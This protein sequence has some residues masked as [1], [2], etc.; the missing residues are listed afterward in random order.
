MKN[1]FTNLSKINHSL[2]NIVNDSAKTCRYTFCK[3]FIT[4]FVVVKSVRHIFL[5]LRFGERRYAA[6]VEHIYNR[7]AVSAA[8]FFHG[9][10]VI[11]CGKVLR[12]FLPRIWIFFCC[13]NEFRLHRRHKHDISCRI[14]RDKSGKHEFNRAVK[15]VLA[16]VVKRA[17]RYAVVKIIDAAHDNDHVAVRAN[18]AH[19]LHKAV[20]SIACNGETGAFFSQVL[21][22]Y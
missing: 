10:Y 18:L 22:K 4:F 1:N 12:I 11:V 5:L 14:L 13:V 6:F 16:T 8:N 7:N 19:T 2:L 21:T 9:V 15:C 20:L 3:T 17:K